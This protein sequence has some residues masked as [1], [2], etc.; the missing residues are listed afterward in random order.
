M[1]RVC[2]ECTACCKSH[3]VLSIDKEPFSWCSDCTVGVGWKR[4]ET[5]PEECK[6]FVCMWLLEPAEDESERPDKSGC[7]ISAHLDILLGDVLTIHELMP[8]A[9]DS[10]RLAQKSK[11]WAMAAGLPIW[12]FRENARGTVLVPKD[13]VVTEGVRIYLLS[14]DV[15]MHRYYRLGR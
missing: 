11:A 9:S 1:K 13:F 10:S 5:R 8:G 2:G 4:Y 14:C 6:D 3:G 7:V 15:A 12:I